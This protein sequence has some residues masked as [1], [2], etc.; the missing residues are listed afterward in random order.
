MKATEIRDFGGIEDKNQ[1]LKSYYNIGFQASH[2]GE[3]IDIIER[4]KKEK[5]LIFFGFTANLVASGLRGIIK[6]FCKKK[7][8]DVVVTTAGAIEHDI[9]KSHKPYF[10]GS[11]YLDD[12]ELHKKGINRIGNILVPNERYIFLEKFVKETFKEMYEREKIISPSELCKEF[13]KKLKD[14]SFL[15]WCNKNNIPVFC[16]GIIDGAI[17][18]QSYFFKQE[19]KDFGID[20]TKDMKEL[21]DLVL[22]AN[23]TSAII[24]G[25][26]IAKHYIIGANILRD[27]L[28]YAV[29]ITTAQEY[30]GSLSGAHTRE[31]KSWGKIKE[32]SKTVVVYGD[33]TITVPIIYYSLKQRNFF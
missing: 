19:K 16:P 31:A 6:E 14:D 23:K 1:L 17:G 2:L 27:G 29:Y 10:L 13:G 30:D 26:G 18:L 33:A 22:N 7:F 5:S 15:Y 25:G 32:K 4:M 12:E 24:I 8:V 11:F 9:M 20:V 3:A 21:A 28:E